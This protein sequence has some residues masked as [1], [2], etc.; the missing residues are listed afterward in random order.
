MFKRLRRRWVILQFVDNLRIKKE[1]PLLLQRS[2][3]GHLQ[4]LARIHISLPAAKEPESL[5]R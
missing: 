1:E 4:N 5:V 2:I 3:K